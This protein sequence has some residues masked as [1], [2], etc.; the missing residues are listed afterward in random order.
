MITRKNRQTGTMISVGRAEDL[1]VDPSAGP[2]ATICEDHGLIVNHRTRALAESHA[3]D[4]LGWCE[5]C[6]EDADARNDPAPDRYHLCGE[7]E[8]RGFDPS[9]PEVLAGGAPHAEC[10]RCG[11]SGKVPHDPAIHAPLDWEPYTPSWDEIEVGMI[12][13]AALDPDFT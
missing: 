12:G 3:P 2:W 6:R 5:G 10:R 1:G 13:R 7:C 8:G 9:D 11:G 4:P